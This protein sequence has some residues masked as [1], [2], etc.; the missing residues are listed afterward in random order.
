MFVA[1]AELSVLLS[2]IL[3]TFYTVR[4]IHT[5][6][7]TSLQEG[8]IIDSFTN[9]LD[10][11]ARL[12]DILL[13]ST[14][15]ILPDPTGTLQLAYYTAEITLC[16]AILRKQNSHSIRRRGE[17]ISMKALGLLQTIQIYRLRAFWWSVSKV[18]FAIVGA[19]MFSMLLTSVD[20]DEASSWESRIDE[21]LSLL[22]AHSITF[23]VTKLSF[24]RL[25]LLQKV[26]RLNDQSTTADHSV[27]TATLEQPAD[28]AV[29]PSWVSSYNQREGECSNT[30]DPLSSW[31]VMNEDPFGDWGDLEWT[32][33]LDLE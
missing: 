6:S 11:W 14:Q 29:V 27:N 5:L 12:H 26:D 4:G 33:L 2:D 19:F 32:S 22:E 16:R 21:Y 3:S 23:D 18:N 31:R 1:M 17:T 28:P 7:D 24:I 30:F 13:R 10:E 25:Q 20:R 8:G 15:K 9:R